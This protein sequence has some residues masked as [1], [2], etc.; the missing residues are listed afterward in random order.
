VTER[1]G[2]RQRLFFQGRKPSLEITKQGRKIM[3]ATALVVMAAFLMSAAVPA[4]ALT[5]AEKETCLIAAGSC[6]NK[7][8]QLEKEVMQMKKEMKAGKKT[9]TEE[10]LKMLDQKIQD[11]LDQLKMMKEKK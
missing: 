6:G 1:G 5:S 11:A 9:Y 8:K 10:D 2:K 7:A 4:F 3:K